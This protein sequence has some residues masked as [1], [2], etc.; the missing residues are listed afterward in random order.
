MS[1]IATE[2]TTSTSTTKTA[3]IAV[4][5]GTGTG[6]GTGTKATTAATY[7]LLEYYLK[8]LRLPEFQQNHTKVADDCQKQNIAYSGYPG[9]T[10]RDRS[11]P[12]Q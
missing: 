11:N 8:Q 9:K 3:A 7:I 2:A 1:T 5:T 10:C 12:A 6:T 4:A